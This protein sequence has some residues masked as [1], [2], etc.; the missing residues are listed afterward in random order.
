MYKDPFYND[1]PWEI[2][3]DEK[4]RII[5]I[6]YLLIPN[7]SDSRDCNERRYGKTQVRRNWTRD[8]HLGHCSRLDQ[9]QY[10]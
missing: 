2:F 4:G 7:K 9:N 6:V 8:R 10:Q 5:G 1:I 3:R